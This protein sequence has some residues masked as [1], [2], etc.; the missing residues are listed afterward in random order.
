VRD[1]SRTLVDAFVATLLPR[2]CRRLPAGHS[3][4]TNHALVRAWAS[5]QPSALS[6]RLANGLPLSVD[7]SDYNGR[8]LYLF[9][10]V[11]PRVL[12]VCRALL[13]PGDIFLDIGANYGAVGLN[14]YH[15][16]APGGEIHLV[17]PQPDLCRRI[18]DTIAEG[19]L[20]H[21]FLHEFGLLDR[22]GVLPLEVRKGHSGKATLV[23][24]AAGSETVRVPVHDVDD[25]LGRVL[26]EGRPFAAKV[27]VEG[28]D[29]I[30]LRALLQRAKLRFVVFESP[31]GS[32]GTTA[33]RMIASAGYL[34]YGI[35][36]KRR[37]VSLHRLFADTDLATFADAVAVRAGSPVSA[38]A[39]LV[40]RD[41]AKLVA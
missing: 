41:L 27:D 22:G 8:M 37:R 13:R 17:E 1:F 18:R 34:V 6:T 2:I 19:H 14:C 25:F 4:I 28:A 35:A 33:W 11:D 12:S 10:A 31:H 40:P 29:T 16:V 24:P 26:P 38:T 23:R 3:R 21:T 36:R 20:D 32:E 5:R 7:V 30:I 15:R 9:G 39:E